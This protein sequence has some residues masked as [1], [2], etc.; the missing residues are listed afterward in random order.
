[1]IKYR[2]MPIYFLKRP[3]LLTHV[4][5]T[6]AQGAP[7][8]IIQVK[9]MFITISSDFNQAKTPRSFCNLGSF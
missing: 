8:E 9:A 3:L 1:M 5:K 7:Y 6:K 2:D 4:L